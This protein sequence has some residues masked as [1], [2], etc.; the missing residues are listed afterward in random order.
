MNALGFYFAGE[1]FIVLFILFFAIVFPLGII[2]LIVYILRRNNKNL[3]VWAEFSQRLGL[4]MPNPKQLSLI[5]VYNSCHVK[6]AIGSR[7]SGGQD[8]T[9]EYYTYCTAAFPQSMRFLLDISA[10]K[11]LLSRI[12]GS[13]PKM[14]LGHSNFDSVFDV[15]CYDQ[16]V[17]QRLLLTDFQSD[18]TQNLMGDLMYTHQQIGIIEISD[19]RVYL[20]RPGQVGQ[21]ELLKQMLDTATFLSGRFQEARR[22]FPLADWEKQTLAS[23]QNLAGEHDLNL[24]PTHFTLNGQYKEFQLEVALKTTAAKWQ[25]EVKI[26]FPRSL[27]TGLKIMPDNAVHKA[28]S[29]FGLQ[30][31]KADNEAFDD[32]FIVK[33]DN[34]VVAKQLL[35]DGFCRQMLGINS[36]ASV[37]S[38][39]DE[40]FSA[41]FDS[42]LGDRKM[43]QSY[44]EGM[45]ATARLLLR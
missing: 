32:A 21:I 28:L 12:I 44:L 29:W 2:G 5:G 43:L 37:I 9:T 22:T 1:I 24:D 3:A 36:R 30:D 34:V 20:E 18:K 19:E 7:R 23:W 31:I 42:V 27:M 35:T 40:E 39:T 15:Q 4:Q 26:I 8:G 11:G 6:L 10:P 25:T 41:T 14:K 38:L 16:N 45:C 17:L 13:S 33:A